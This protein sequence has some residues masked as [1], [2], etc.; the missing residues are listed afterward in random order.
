MK[1]KKK[2]IFTLALAGLMALSLISAS[3]VDVEKDKGSITVTIQSQSGDCVEGVEVSIYQVGKGRVEDH[4]LYFDV[5][6]PLQ[7]AQPLALDEEEQEVELSRLTAQQNQDA[8]QTL[9]DR[10]QELPAGTVSALTKKTDRDGKVRFENLNVGAYLVVQSSENDMYYNFDSFL[11]CLPSTTPDGTAWQY[12]MKASPKVEARPQEPI[13]P[14]DP[15]TD[16][17]DLDVPIDNILPQTGVLK[18]PIPVMAIS[19]LFLFSAG[20]INDRK[21][22]K[23]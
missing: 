5:V 4:N 15:P 9:Y 22:K 14:E 1:T 21:A 3:A 8:A 17:P 2:T 6:Q 16:I 19:G 12:A 7:P 10:I 13:P 20:W 23:W 18:W 11:V